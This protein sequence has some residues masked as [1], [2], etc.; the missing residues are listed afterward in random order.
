MSCDVV[1]TYSAFPLQLVPARE[2]RYK[3]QL[4]ALHDQVLQWTRIRTTCS[5]E[6]RY[7]GVSVYTSS[8]LC[9]GA[10]RGGTGGHSPPLEK[11]DYLEHFASS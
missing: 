11:L 2:F 10:F 8:G 1:L 6:G 5:Y 3:T 7:I 9:R 4:G